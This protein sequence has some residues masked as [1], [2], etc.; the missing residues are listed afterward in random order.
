MM[1]CDVS[2]VAMFSLLL[3]IHD[4]GSTFS[5]IAN[6]VVAD[7]GDEDGGVVNI[8]YICQCRA[9]SLG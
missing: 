9:K 1:A 2:P 4:G 5:H 3:L 8:V 7:D 6:E